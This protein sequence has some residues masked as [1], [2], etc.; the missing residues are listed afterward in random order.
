MLFLMDSHHFPPPH[1]MQAVQFLLA[2]RERLT[3]QKADN[4]KTDRNEMDT[5]QQQVDP[6]QVSGILLWILCTVCVHHHV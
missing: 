3:T 4:V 6:I 1:L 5:E 2:S